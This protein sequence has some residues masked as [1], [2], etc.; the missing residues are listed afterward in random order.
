M[1]QFYQLQPSTHPDF[2]DRLTALYGRVLA[3]P[4]VRASRRRLFAAG[5]TSL[6][7]AS[8]DDLERY[9]AL[10]KAEDETGRKNVAHTAVQLPRQWSHYAQLYSARNAMTHDFIASPRDYFHFAI[11]SLEETDDET[12]AILCH[13]SVNWEDNA[14]SFE[15][16]AR[17]E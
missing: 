15:F 1:S 14:P 2:Q 17:A 8:I 5:M 16:M 3:L 10:R 9:A 12:F 6:R 11:Y 7:T 13:D 4:K